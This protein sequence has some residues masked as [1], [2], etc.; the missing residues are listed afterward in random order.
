[1]LWPRCERQG[2]WVGHLTALVEQQEAIK[3]ESLIVGQMHKG[4][5]LLFFANFILAGLLLYY[6]GSRGIAPP[7]AGWEYKDLITVILT[8]LAA[9]LGALAILI[10]G[11]LGAIAGITLALTI[12]LNRG[13]ETPNFGRPTAVGDL[14]DF[15]FAAIG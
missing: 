2:R 14:G 15:C 5:W 8:T 6:I 10:G 3:D 12:N 13:H 11:I 4:N 9:L 1:M 7:P